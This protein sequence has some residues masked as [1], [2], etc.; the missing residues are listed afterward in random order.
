MT[1]IGILGA[2]GR[3]GQEIAAAVPELGASVAGGIDKGGAAQGPYDTAAALAQGSDVLIDFS[4]PAGLQTHL[5]AAIRAG[6]PIVI[7]TTGLTDKH[8]RDIDA[9][10]AKVAVLQSANMSLGVNLLRHFVQEA[11]ARLGPDWD[12]EILE[13]HHRDKIDAPSGTA[14]MLGDAA[15]KGRG[16]KAEE[17]DRLDRM[18]VTQAREPGTIGYASLR[19]GKVAGDHTDVCAAA[20]ERQERRQRA[21]RRRI[22][23][24]GAVQAALWLAGKPAGRYQMSDVLGL[25]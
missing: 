21:A 9:A 17:L 23:P 19:G 16:G 11:A 14:L 20:A 15:A 18:S 25:P 5:D 7:G 13:M 1:T 4:S 22:I 12:V 3:M 6:C 8:H 24:R 10:C 2:L